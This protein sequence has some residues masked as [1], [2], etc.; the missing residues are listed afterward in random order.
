MSKSPFLETVREN[1]RLRGYSLRTEQTYLHWIRRFIL[2]NGKKHPQ[3][4]HAVEVR[5]FLNWLANKRNV[6]I[7]TQ[8]VAL[9]ALVFLYKH[10]VQH[11]LGDLGF[12]QAAK[13]RFLPVVLTPQQVLSIIEQLNGHHKLIVSLLYGSGLRISE[14]LRLRVQDIDLTN[15]S[16]TVRDSKGHKD[17]QTLLSAKL[18][19]PLQQQIAAALQV[20][21][22]DNAKGIGPSLPYALSGKYPNAFRQPGWMFV[23]PS[24]SLCPHPLTGELCRHHLHDSIIR[25]AL[26]PAVAACQIRQR[27]GCHTFRHS[28]AT[29]LLQNGCDIRT[30]QELLGHNDVTTTQIYTHVIGQHYAGTISPLDR[31]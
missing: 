11:E 31:S 12:T 22:Q 19:E 18:T 30:V 2:F 15:F 28:F 8:K 25:K 1:I 7:N 9:N 21:Q 16:L 3:D 13:Q 26:A 29:H 6:A 20:Q 5:D 24:T 27:V 4:M 17:R 10:I 23:F 14:C